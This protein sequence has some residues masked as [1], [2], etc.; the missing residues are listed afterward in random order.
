[1]SDLAHSVVLSHFTVPSGPRLYY[2][3]WMPKKPRAILVVVHGWSEHVGRYGPLVRH[4][5][6]CGYGVALYDQRG[7]GNSG[8]P[9]GHFDSF[10]DL[11]GDLAHFI[12]SVR[13]A[14]PQV[15]LF[16]VG[17]SFGGQVALN[18][19][20][21]YAKGLRG[22]IVSSPNIRLALPIPR[23]KR[24]I[25]EHLHEWAPK[26]LVRQ[27][28]DATLLTHDAQVA[29]AYAAD[30]RVVHGAS[31]RA[32]Q[33]ILR[34]LDV[35]MALAS[36]IHLPS[37]FMHAGADAVCD[38]EGTRHFFRRIPV[39]RKRLKVYDGY[40]HELFNEVGRDVVFRDM[41]QWIDENLRDERGAEDL[42]PGDIPRRV[43]P[44]SVADIQ[45]GERWLGPI[46]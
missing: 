18:F 11:L 42:E 27:R 6:E 10:Q 43:L 13:Q 32:G 25:S 41:T 7:H 36:R 19:V 17:H 22:L 12:Q 40:Y 33:E 37:L 23:W 39:T 20:V 21:R 46:S 31:L 3:W 8:G 45:R 26:L 29:R 15:P 24:A 34:N 38:P 44:S 1:M 30:P 14:Y 9:R 16:L 28:I 5:V 2:E 35:V 4:F